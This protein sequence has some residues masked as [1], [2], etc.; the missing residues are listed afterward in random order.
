MRDVAIIGAGETKYGEHWDKSLRDL[1]VE[2]GLKALED[3]GI[4]AEDIQAIFGGNMSAGSFVG[5]D[6]VGALMA[7]FAGL[8]ETM[9]PAMRIES[10]CAS[11]AAALHAGY[12]AVASG[13]YDIVLVGGVEKMTDLPGDMVTDI[14]AGAADREWE[15][16]FG[17]TFPAL[18][19]MMAR[20]YMYE[21]GMTREQMALFPVIAHKHGALNPDAHFQREITVDTVLNSAM[22][23]DPLTIMNC[24]PVSDG[25]AAVV[26]APAEIARKYTDSPIK[27]SA[28]TFANEYISLHS[29]ESLVRSVSTIEAGKKAY[30]MAKKEPKD[31]DLVEIHDAFSII[32]IIGLEDLGF[33]KKGEAH[34]LAEEGQLYYD[35]DLPYNP[36][37]GLKAKG[38][39]VGATGVGQVVEIVKQLR[40]EAGKRQVEDAKVGLAHNVGGTMTSSIIHILEVM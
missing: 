37:G 9:I 14:L 19:A 8:A 22:V 3:A 11:G 13:L 15:V 17:A 39:P 7:D 40:N 20:R 6:H 30:K 12:M 5:Q 23:A 24:S 34:K 31:I 4:Y 27:I 2:A 10:A 28:S 21:F 32:A 1:A 33:A 16:F 29:R 38:H 36:S 18:G 26:L 35:G 25:A